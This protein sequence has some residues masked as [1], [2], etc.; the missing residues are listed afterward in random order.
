VVQT[1]QA[2]GIRINAFLGKGAYSTV[3]S[4]EDATRGKV[5]AAKMIST[6]TLRMR[7]IPTERLLR[8]IEIMQRLQHLDA[9][10]RASAAAPGDD[11]M[12]RRFAA[13]GDI[14][15]K[16]LEFKYLDH[17]IATV[18]TIAGY[19]EKLGAG[20]T[21]KPSDVLMNK[22]MSGGMRSMKKM[23]ETQYS[24]LRTL[25]RMVHFKSGAAAS[26]PWGAKDNKNSFVVALYSLGVYVLAVWGVVRGIIKR[27]RGRRP[28]FSRGLSI[29]ATSIVVF[30]CLGAQPC[31][32]S[33]TMLADTTQSVAAQ[34]TGPMPFHQN[35]VDALHVS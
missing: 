15:S 31:G 26:T 1:L 33:A 34:T 25:V 30:A 4:A 22:G 23:S 3:W 10:H 5:F 20:F 28:A 27:P 12:S 17:E 21:F 11:Y 35:A 24:A 16:L 13:K 14:K 18:N 7:K 8:E 6:A 19:L 29:A 32:C 9:T 2:K